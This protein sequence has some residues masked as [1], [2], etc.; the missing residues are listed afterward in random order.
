[1]RRAGIAFLLF[2]HKTSFR[3]PHYERV[4]LIDGLLLVYLMYIYQLGGNWEAVITQDAMQRC[5]RRA[6]TLMRPEHRWKYA[7]LFKYLRAD[8]RDG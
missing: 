2:V 1:M 7:G 8:S 6:T 3:K 5:G 4:L